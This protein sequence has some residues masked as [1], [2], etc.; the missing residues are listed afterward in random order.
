MDQSLL[1]DSGKGFIG[2]GKKFVDWSSSKMYVA[3]C[4]E[5]QFF[6]DNYYES[7]LPRPLQC[8]V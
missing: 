7:F 8:S 5:F 1:I 2:K 4:K 3:R 6:V